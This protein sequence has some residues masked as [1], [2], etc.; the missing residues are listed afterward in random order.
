M[1]ALCL[2]IYRVLSRLSAMFLVAAH[3]QLRLSL[4]MALLLIRCSDSNLG[5]DFVLF[6]ISA[7]VLRP[8]SV[9]VVAHIAFQYVS[10]DFHVH[11]HIVC[12]KKY[13]SFLP[14]YTPSISLSCRIALA[15][16]SSARPSRAA[17][18]ASCLVPAVFTVKYG[19]SGGSSQK[20]LQV[21]GFF[22]CAAPMSLGP[23]VPMHQLVT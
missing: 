14:I 17:H 22:S 21:W 18:G 1:N 5:G 7:C 11:D 10:E 8:C 9:N 4:S 3:I 13:S 23:V 20:P 19:V 12:G 6:L 2:S 16:T 15:E